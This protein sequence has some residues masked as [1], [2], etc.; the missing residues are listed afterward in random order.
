M[1]TPN[2]YRPWDVSGGCVIGREHLGS[3]NVFL[4]KN[5]QDAFAIL[6]RPNF[7]VAAVADGCSSGP[8]SEVGAQLGVHL[9][10]SQVARAWQRMSE[11]L[12]AGGGGDP[13]DRSFWSRV[14]L[15][16]LA[17]LS[18]LALALSAS[19]REFGAIAAHYLQFTI[20]GILDTP[21]GTWIWAPPG[22]D[23]YFAI[24]GE[25]TAL[26]APQIAGS[27]Q[28]GETPAYP[29]YRLVE[30]A[31][32]G[33]EEL[34]TLK[35]IAY[36]PPGVVQSF[37]LGTDGVRY[38]EQNQAKPL[39]GSEEPMGSVSQFWTDRVYTDAEDEVTARLR[40][41]NREVTR[42]GTTPKGASALNRQPG[43][44]RDDVAIVVGRRIENRNP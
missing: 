12:R 25:L 36:Y 3:G 26:T 35:A 17:P 5:G 29:I 34:I 7:M 41:M 21:L 38:I 24:N 8:A 20:L 37:L 14:Q 19:D 9:H 13:L 18:T 1:H 11:K 33:N 4:G 16:A 31:F 32:A 43:L 22:T 28:K 40:L 2:D 15:N 42:L 6:K 23:G 39:P 44:L 27:E 10:T 30:N